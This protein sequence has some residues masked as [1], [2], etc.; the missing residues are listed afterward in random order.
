MISRKNGAGKSTLLKIISCYYKNSGKVCFWRRTLWKWKILS[1]ICFTSSDRVLPSY[2]K[3][4]EILNILKEFY[5]NWDEK[6][7]KELIKIWIRWNKVFDSLQR[8]G[9]AMVNLII[10][11]ARERL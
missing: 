2:L 9:K 7:R 8:W 11:L 3:I 10:G 5:P 6:F 1:Q 4:G